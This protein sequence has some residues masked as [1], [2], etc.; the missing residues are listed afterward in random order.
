MLLLLHLHSLPPMPL[1]SNPSAW[2]VVVHSIHNSLLYSLEFD[3][4]HVSLFLD[5]LN[6]NILVA[7]LVYQYIL[8]IFVYLIYE[9]VLLL[10]TYDLFHLPV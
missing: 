1:H 8:Y 10:D 7:S 5:M 6:P 4:I 9:H 2:V 3:N